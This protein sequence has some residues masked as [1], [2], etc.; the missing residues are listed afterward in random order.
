MTLF[1]VI[2]KYLPL[3]YYVD[4]RSIWQS[5]VFFVYQDKDYSV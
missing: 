1:L 2:F 4:G 3:R 5:C